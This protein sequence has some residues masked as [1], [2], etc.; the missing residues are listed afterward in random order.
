[1]QPLSIGLI[2]LSAAA[3]QSDLWRGIPVTP[4][5]ILSE[6]ESPPAKHEQREEAFVA[7]FKQA[8]ARDAEIERLPLHPSV[9]P[10]LAKA[11]DRLVERL[12]SADAPASEVEAALAALDRRHQRLGGNVR[13]V[14]PGRTERVIGFGAHLDAAEGSPGV[15]DNWAAC[16]LLSNLYQTL[17]S[18]RPQHTLWFV[19]FAEEEIGCLGSAAFAESLGGKTSRR[20]DAFVTLDCAGVA[21][22]MVWWSGSSAGAV[23]IAADLVRQAELPLAVVDFPGDSSDGLSLKR[24]SI[25]VISLLGIDPP[26]LSL[27]HGPEDRIEN[28]D[29]RRIEETF[30]LLRALAAGLDEHAQPLLW[31]YA[32]AKLRLNDP[33]SGRKPIR[34]IKLDLAAAPLPLPKDAP[35][36]PED[37]KP[38]DG[39]RP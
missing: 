13:V 37:R 4:Q 21:S 30:E 20:I 25:P 23:E 18:T 38:R 15:I 22:P 12:K 27:L 2:A 35:A 9:A 28:V 39:S 10:H 5:E 26:R 24:R 17:R 7:L 33:A 19:G 3:P 16:A 34:P 1:M 32:K 29:R 36:P 31:D 6:I 11:R 14:L 8:G